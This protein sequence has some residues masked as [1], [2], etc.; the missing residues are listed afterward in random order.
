MKKK[1]KLSTFTIVC[2]VLY[3]LSF[4]LIFPN[5]S[6][7]KYLNHT[8]D[9]GNNVATIADFVFLVENQTDTFS[10]NLEEK[11]SKPGESA[12]YSFVIRNYDQSLT[13]VPI[14]YEIILEVVGNMP[15]DSSLFRDG[16]KQ[17]TVSTVSTSKNT[18]IGIMDIT[19]TEIG[20]TI[21]VVWPEDRV[22]GSYFEQDAISVIFLTIK[23]TQ[24]D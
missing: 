12:N 7:A 1:F 20:F 19:E 22:D 3:I 10:F 23:A 8:N 17:F 16:Q 4:I 5:I 2:L 9:N 13:E 11:I 21:E 15:I 18:C 6:Q 14:Q 24:I